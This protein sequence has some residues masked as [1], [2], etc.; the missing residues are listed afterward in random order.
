VHAAP[1]DPRIDH[2]R[3]LLRE[4]NFSEA[5]PAYE[6]LTKRFSDKAEIWVE[7]GC[8]A[9]NALW[10]DVARRAWDKALEL[11]ANDTELLLQIGQHC[12]HF[13]MTDKA[14]ASFER[15]MAV[16]S[17]GLS[18]RIALATLLEKSH[19]LAEA[20]ETVD[21]CL[22]ID[23]RDE[24]ARF[25]SALL[26]R[27]E[28]KLADAERKLRDLIA[29]G[30]KHPFVQV[31]SRHEL[32][33]VLDRTER[34]DEAIETLSEAKRLVAASKDISG[35]LQ[36]YDIFE[37][38]YRKA[39]QALPANILRTWSKEFPAK[40]RAAI[41]RLAFLGGHPRS[42]TTLLEQVMGAHPD[43]AALDEPF[44]FTL[45]VVQLFNS[46]PELSPARLNIIRRR[47]VEAMQKELGDEAQRKVFLD[48]NPLD[49]MK[50]R[51][52]LRVFPELRVV[53][54]LRDPRDV[55]LSCYFQNIELNAFSANFLYLERTARHY[56]N[57]MDVWLAVRKWEG[58]S[59]IES[60]YEDIVADVAKEG[61]RVSEFLG[62]DWKPEQE[63]FHQKSRAKAIRAPTYHDVRQPVYRR[64]VSKWRAYEKYLAP[65][66]AI[67]EPYCRAFG[68]EV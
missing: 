34:F 2:A 66:Q 41:P 47:Y 23:A 5:I 37:S 40:S 54:A 17:H 61:R 10:L 55:V 60:R 1:R 46:S 22:A 39:T 68:Y 67:L 12:Q 57:L 32:A 44:A 56:A 26:D 21:A 25:L 51:I 16:D 7:Y 33:Q 29:S 63:A 9:A 35:M 38:K 59:F 62:L 15:A 65:C 4:C 53:T 45:V 14:K 64:S 48:K 27:R 18:P 30:P 36:Q 58:L 19:R 11:E 28:N 31:A 3:K 13:H 42:G 52:R 50:L 20:R 49:T 43:V 24:Q 8:A 6:K